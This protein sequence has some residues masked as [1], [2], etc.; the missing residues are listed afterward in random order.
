MLT[1]HL[2]RHVMDEDRVGEIDYLIGDDAY[3]KSWMDRRQERWGLVAY[4]PLSLRGTMGL[5]KTAAG[6]LTEPWRKKATAALG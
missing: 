3:K 6:A 2:M 4:N 1:A 5:L